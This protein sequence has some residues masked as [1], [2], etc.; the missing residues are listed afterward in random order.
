MKI[1]EC[2]LCCLSTC[3]C[4]DTITRYIA[5]YPPNPPGYRI[6]RI[7]PTLKI[8]LINEDGSTTE[9]IKIRWIFVSVLTLKTSLNSVIP[10][11]FY[12]N[13]SADQNIIYAHGNSTDIGFLYNYIA[14][15]S[16][17][18]KANVLLFEYTGYGES[19]KKPS[20]KNLYADIKVAY[21]YLITSGAEPKNIILYG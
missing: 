15:F 1:L 8:K 3:G 4:K 11:L 7:G 19:T 16:M 9:P 13:M 18:V 12:K 2:F 10:A 20:E 5:F 21:D 14:D 6:N 17:Q